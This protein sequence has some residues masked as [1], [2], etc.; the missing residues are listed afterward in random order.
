M[1]ESMAVLL[2]GQPCDLTFSVGGRLIRY[3]GFCYKVSAHFPGLDPSTVPPDY[4]IKP[5]KNVA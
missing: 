2:Y 3:E 4:W 5:T 1:R